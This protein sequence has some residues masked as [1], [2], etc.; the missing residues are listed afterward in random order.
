M[1]RKIIVVIIIAVLIGSIVGFGLG[2]EVYQPEI[3]KLQNNVNNANAKI[4]TLNSTL[5][6]AQST[7]LNL[8]SKLVD[9]NST[10]EEINNGSWHEVSSL[11]GSSS[12]I[13][14]TFQIKGQWMRIRWYMA[15]S[16]AIAWIR[17]YVTF[18]NGTLYADRGSSGVYG[19]YSC[20]L[21]HRN[22]PGEYYIDVTA[23]YVNDYS[24]TIW[25]YY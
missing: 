4:Q 21:A 18:A 13:S 10:V 15:A 7:I 22:I 8:N 9:L 20:D 6:N 24:V 23:N 2:Y 1:E 12:A 19:S 16:T 11:N 17:I 14:E 3:S 5:G 25:D